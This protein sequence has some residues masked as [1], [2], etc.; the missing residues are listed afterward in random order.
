[1][2]N[3]TILGMIRYQ[4]EDLVA[5]VLKDLGMPCN[6]RGYKQVRMALLMC[7]E[8]PEVLDHIVRDIYGVVGPSF[9]YT[10]SGCERAIRY[11]IES[12]WDRAEP[13]DIRSY[14]G[15]TVLASKGRP[16]NKEFLSLLADAISRKHRRKEL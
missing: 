10:A 7:L 14:F 16:S 4:A 1:M 5:D 3:E 13:E 12:T 8:K 9:G 6:V 11:A 2:E 15:N